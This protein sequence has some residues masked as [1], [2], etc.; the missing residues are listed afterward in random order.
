MGDIT[1]PNQL[2]D[3]RPIETRRPGRL[4]KRQLGGQNSDIE[5]GHLLP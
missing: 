4:L 1:H 5:T 3:Y 2:I